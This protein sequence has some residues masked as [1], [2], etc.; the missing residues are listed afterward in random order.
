MAR[1]SFSTPPENHYL[2]Q[3]PTLG[4]TCFRTSQTSMGAHRFHSD[5]DCDV[6]LLI[7]LGIALFV[8]LAL[9]LTTPLLLVLRYRAGKARRLGRRWIATLN[10]VMIA[11]SSAIFLWAA[12]MTSFW[13]PDAFRY[14]LMGLVGGGLLGL[15]GLALT[16]WEETPQTLHYTPNRWL[17]LTI[18][19]TVTARLLYGLWRI[20]HAWRTAGPDTSWVA[21]ASVAGSMAVGAIVLGYYLTYSA[22]VRWRLRNT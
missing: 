1:F 6:P 2:A 17:I 5:V 7:P 9:V 13:V 4:G 18:T 15:L 8:L 3:C 20:W 16:R 12:A 21:S 10:L 22:G 14:S 19:L 11:L